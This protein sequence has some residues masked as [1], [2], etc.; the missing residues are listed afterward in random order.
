MA[1]TARDRRKA[2]ALEERRRE[3]EEER[4]EAFKERRREIEEEDSSSPIPLSRNASSRRSANSGLR[5]S[6]NFFSLLILNLRGLP[7]FDLIQVYSLSD[8]SPE[9]TQKQ[10]GDTREGAREGQGRAREE[11]CGLLEEVFGC[12]RRCNFMGRCLPQLNGPQCPRC[13]HLWGPH[14]QEVPGHQPGQFFREAPS[15]ALL[16]LAALT[17]LIERGRSCN[18]GWA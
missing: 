14:E 18:D 11:E 2:E 17:G 7:T 8:L 9:E 13:D 5:H 15:A 3:V 4:A 10:G 6:F 1:P 12:R 16:G